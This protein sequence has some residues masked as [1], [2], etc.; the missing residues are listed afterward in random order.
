M[1]RNFVRPYTTILTAFLVTA[2][3][4]TAVAQAPASRYEEQRQNINKNTI[5]IMG[6]QAKTA[7]TEFAQDMQNVLDDPESGGMRILPIL[8]RGGGQNFLDILFLQGIDVG[9]VERDVIDNYKEKDPT[10]YGN[11]GTRLRYI[12]KLTNSEM[13]FFARHEIKKLEDLRGKKVSFYKPDSSSD[14]AASFILDTCQIKTEKVYAD[15][16]LGAEMLKKGE[17]MAVAR[18]SGAP[19]SALTNFTSE[20][21]HFIPMDEENLPP[22]CF[23]KLMK[24][25]LPAFLKQE[26]YPKVLQ[27]GELVPTV[28]NATIL[29]TYNFPAQ[30]ERY[31]VVAKFVNALFDNIDKFRDGPRHPKWKEVN[32][33]AEVPGWTRF[34]PAQEWINA[35]AKTAGGSRSDDVKTAFE[36]YLQERLRSSGA[37]ALTEP[38]KQALLEEFTKWWKQQNASRRQ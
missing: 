5:T 36:R 16:D 19:H 28:A 26:H 12:L 34:A 27:E 29:V 7:Y 13:H 25:F 14:Q 3:I 6:S 32:I 1:F 18:I 31:G 17:L 8:G 10:L 23:Q 15:T 38:Q 4:Y 21:G 37:P 20:D 33:A 2:P 24:S 9:M 35:H 22:G 11:I 30:T